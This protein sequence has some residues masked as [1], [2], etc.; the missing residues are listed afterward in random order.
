MHRAH[1]YRLQT[2][3]RSFRPPSRLFTP[4]SRNHLHALSCQHSP[5]AALMDD[6]E[7]NEP[8]HINENNEWSVI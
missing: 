2:Q 7:N 6:L 4:Q 5:L 8:L 1:G 3:T